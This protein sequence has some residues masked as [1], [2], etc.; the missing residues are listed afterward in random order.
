MF[1]AGMRALSFSGCLIIYVLSF[2]GCLEHSALQRCGWRKNAK[3]M[4]IEFLVFQ[5]GV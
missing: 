2:D 4:Y 3:V 1:F 5:R